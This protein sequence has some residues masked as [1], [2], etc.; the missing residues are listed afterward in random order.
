M[1]D[2]MQLL[3]PDAMTGHWEFTYGE[4]R[5]KET[6]EGLG[7]PFLALNIRDTE[8]NEPAFRRLRRCF[9]KAASRSR[10]SAKPSPIR[11]L[12]IRAG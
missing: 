2:C 4:E 11:R 12:P 9:D 7:F 1:V 6:V 3:E 10:F 8:W 5:V